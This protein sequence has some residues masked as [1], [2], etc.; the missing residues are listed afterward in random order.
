MNINNIVISIAVVSVVIVALLVFSDNNAQNA[1]SVEVA[2]VLSSQETYFDFGT[3][4]MADGEVSH[5]F[6]VINNGEE[7]IVIKKV[8]TSCMCTTAFIKNGAGKEYGGFSM[9]GHGGFA[10]ADINVGPGEAIAVKA[11]FDPAAH[12]PSGVG[13][14]QRS[15]Y[16][17]TNST[18]SPKLEL[19]FRATVVR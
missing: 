6:N 17:E 10:K 15:I 4:S 8:Y 1:S 2:A 13:L 14:A 19:T 9:P 3:I 11:V 18:Q 7:P 16:L 12:G 5:T